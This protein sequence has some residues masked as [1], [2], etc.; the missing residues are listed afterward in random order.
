MN[1]RRAWVPPF[2]ASALL[3]GMAGDAG[4]QAPSFETMAQELAALGVEG[5]PWSTVVV[6]TVLVPSGSANDPDG[7]SGATRLLA[8]MVRARAERSLQPGDA[9]I[10]IEVERAHTIFQAMAVPEAW[11][12]V[13][14][15]L[16]DAIFAAPL[17]ADALDPER[18][19]L[20]ATARFESGAPVREFQDELYQVVADGD[21]VW[22]ADPRG[23]PES[24]QRID[25]ASLT[26]LRGRSY[27][28][29]ESMVTLVGALGTGPGARVYR[30]RTA[31]LLGDRAAGRPAW[32][33]G[34]RERLGRQVTNSWIGAA[35]PVP[36]DVPRTLLDFIRHRVSEEL[37]PEPPDP[38]L[39]GADVRI[40]EMAG[41]TVLLVEAAVLPEAEER[42]EQRVVQIVEDV[43]ERH[44][45]P[46]FFRFQ[47]RRFRT[48][49]LVE[50]GAPEVAGRRMAT[51]LLRTGDLRD[52]DKEIDDMEPGALERA[53]DGLGE[54]RVLVFGPDLGGGDG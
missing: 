10:S 17:P 31:A 14:R 40:E 49:F 41:G 53:V 28:R 51:D 27:R 6:M 3:L 42:W 36:R 44:R 25:N 15:Q 12:R 1:R 37:N 2:L 4:A 13:Y 18:R 52:L 20:L 7:L 45:D 46:G 8:E 32:S 29:A 33:D 34:D 23:S 9:R 30:G 5:R 11:E 43:G 54:P 39:F 38:G 22:S 21:P 47:R 16:L 35:F 26:A 19:G 48:A 24:L 50:E